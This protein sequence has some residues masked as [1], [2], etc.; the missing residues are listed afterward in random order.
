MWTGR[1]GLEAAC[2]V[3]PSWFV[4]L[5]YA[6]DKLPASGSLS[7]SDWRAFSKGI[8]CRYFGVG[9]YGSLYGRPHYHALLF[10]VPAGT[11]TAL[12]TQRWSH[13]FASVLPFTRERAQYCAGYVCKKWTRPD[14]VELAGRRPEFSRMSRRPGVGIPGLVWLAQW[15]VTAEGAKFIARTKD[16]PHQVRVDGQFYPLGTT[17]VRYLRLEAG[18]PEKDPNRVRNMQTRNEIL[19]EEFPDLARLRE[20]RRV[21]RYDAARAREARASKGL[22]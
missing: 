8:G 19:E 18:L 20:V 5:T 6:D 22:Q 16:V 3:H 11:I 14:A 1:L 15:L 17:C 7:A 2:Q 12:V 21:V 9:E 4:T 10:G 13:G